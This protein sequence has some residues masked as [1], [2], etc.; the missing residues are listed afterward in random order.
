MSLEYAMGC[1]MPVEVA[2]HYLS[3]VRNPMSPT[4]R[5]GLMW[6]SYF[7]NILWNN[8]KIIRSAYTRPITVYLKYQT[9]VILLGQ[10]RTKFFVFIFEF[11]L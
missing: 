5:V 2:I 3:Y 9:L 4:W 7:W 10:M 6:I 8:D 1:D 11:N